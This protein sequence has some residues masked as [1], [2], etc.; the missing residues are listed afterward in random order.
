MRKPISKDKI[1]KVERFILSST[2]DQFDKLTLDDDSKKIN[3]SSPILMTLMH[4]LGLKDDGNENNILDLYFA[5]KKG[6]KGI[7]DFY[8]K[9]SLNFK[10][11]KEVPQVGVNEPQIED[12]RLL[13]HVN[14]LMSSFNFDSKPF[15]DYVDLTNYINTHQLHSLD[16]SSSD[17]SLQQYAQ[18]ILTRMELNKYMHN[19]IPISEMLILKPELTGIE[20]SLRLFKVNGLFVIYDNA[21]NKFFRLDT[22]QTPYRIEPI[23]NEDA[24]KIGSKSYTTS[25]SDNS[26]K[27]D[28][29]LTVVQPQEETLSVPADLNQFTDISASYRYKLIESKLVG[30]GMRINSDS[31]VFIYVD[32]PKDFNKDEKAMLLGRLSLWYDKIQQIN[33]VLLGTY[34]N[35]TDYK[36]SLRDK[37]ILNALVSSCF[38]GLDNILEINDF[39]L[40]PGKVDLDRIE[41]IL[42]RKHGWA[43]TRSFNRQRSSSDNRLAICSTLYQIV[44]AVE[45]SIDGEGSIL[46]IAESLEKINIKIAIDDNCEFIFTG[47]QSLIELNEIQK[48]FI[49]GR[50]T[51]SLLE[52]AKRINPNLDIAQLDYSFNYPNLFEQAII[53]I[54]STNSDDKNIDLFDLLEEIEK[55]NYSRLFQKLSELGWR[56]NLNNDEAGKI[57]ISQMLTCFVNAIESEMFIKENNVVDDPTFESKDTVTNLPLEKN[58]LESEISVDGESFTLEIDSNQNISNSDGIRIV[59][60]DKLLANL[61]YTNIPTGDESLVLQL[62]LVETSKNNEEEVTVNIY[63]GEQIT[64]VNDILPF[65]LDLKFN[66]ISKLAEIK[67]KAFSK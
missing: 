17:S 59:D 61:Y 25:F 26:L 19:D 58:N 24:I 52:T 62:M 6:G 7:S 8:N 67:I 53:Q 50:L 47:K 35:L 43:S 63:P 60:G 21:S 18:S 13:E 55:I 31:Q 5:G 28:E 51:L 32:L 66:S 40:N 44:K 20:R 41:D 11:E 14:S 54:I 42:I 48:N 38:K 64:L 45:T 2:L 27:L 57:A 49:T 29:V 9:V 23:Q 56:S 12:D 22:R 4:N 16:D 34:D 33:Y 36:L 39:L 37:D 15:K 46:K 65:D 1:N 30:R 3:T 10:I